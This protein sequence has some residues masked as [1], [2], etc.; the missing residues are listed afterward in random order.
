MG[1]SCAR[2]IVLARDADH[3]DAGTDVRGLCNAG[4]IADA[5]TDPRG[6]A[7]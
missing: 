5:G 7:T 2:E 3:N 6:S 4:A 1:E